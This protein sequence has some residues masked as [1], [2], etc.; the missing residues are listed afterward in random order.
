MN[1]GVTLPALKK[2][3]DKPVIKPLYTYLDKEKGGQI[4][5]L[6]A[7]FKNIE[8]LGERSAAGL[9]DNNGA[10]LEDLPLHSLAE[11]NNL[12]K[13]DVIIKIGNSPVNSLSDLMQAYQSIKWM[14]VADCIIIRN[15]SEMKLPV[16]FK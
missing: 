10:M 4:E 13:G 1:F 8:T 9:H 2:I 16:S 3:A 5:W 14:G 11:K 12:K 6:G 7:T 15:Q